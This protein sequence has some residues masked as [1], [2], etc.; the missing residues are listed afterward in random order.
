MKFMSLLFKKEPPVT[1]QADLLQLAATQAGRALVIRRRLGVKRGAE[2]RKWTG[3]VF[4]KR[5]WVGQPVV[6]PDQSVGWIKQVQ[7]GYA[8]VRTAFTDPVD[9]AV[10]QY[11]EATA[12][13]RYRLPEAVLLGQLKRGVK[14]VASAAKA[15]ASR[16][17]GR[18]PPQPGSRRRGRPRKGKSLPSVQRA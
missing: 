10:H 3:F 18:L 1:S 5:A 14:E 6:L 11:L 16:L 8:C 12:L 15:A 2:N 13:R 7:A 17:N 4:G 9:G